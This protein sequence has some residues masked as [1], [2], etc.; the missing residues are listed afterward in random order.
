MNSRMQKRNR[1]GVAGRLA[2]L[3]LVF[4]LCFGNSAVEAGYTE[5]FDTFTNNIPPAGWGVA[6]TNP[7]YNDNPQWSQGYIAD[8]SD[9]NVLGFNA[10]A[11]P[12]TS[13]ASVSYAAGY[14]S[15]TFVWSFVN[16]WLLT[17]ELV[18]NNGDT[19]SFW[20]RQTAYYGTGYP[21]RMEVRL[22]TNGNSNNIGAGATSTGDFS[23]LVLD[24][25]PTLAGAGFPDSWTQYTATITSLTGANVQGRIG[26]RYFFSQ[27]EM[28][29][30]LGSSYIGVDTFAT[31]ANLP[32]PP[33][34]EPASFVLMGLG[35]AGL[36]YV[37]HRRSKLA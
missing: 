32:V 26:F 31:T 4:G 14:D 1:S 6:Y 3:G 23:T 5:N 8:G 22:S 7:G 33:V 11:G 30:G 10:Q 13:Y 35:L 29:D 24:I 37:R 27:N 21:N 15:D 2:I 17:P 18:M 19:V 9:T 34:P 36:G 12:A 16:T 28:N 25:N 20:S